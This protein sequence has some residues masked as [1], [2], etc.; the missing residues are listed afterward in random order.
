MSRGITAV[1][2]PLDLLSVV[3][4]ARNEAGCILRTVEHLHLELRM[5]SIPHE[6]VVVDD[7]STDDT[8]NLLAGATARI[9]NLRPIQNLADH[10]FGRAVS[11][12][13][14]SIHGDAVVIMMADGSDDCRDV[15]G[16][17]VCLNGVGMRSSARDSCAA[18][19]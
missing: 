17:W 19:V 11:K 10:G 12:G 6:I 7:G 4:P 16:Y 9:P 15:V 1:Q 2:P 3:I 5:H 13:L 14:D 18:P 8:W